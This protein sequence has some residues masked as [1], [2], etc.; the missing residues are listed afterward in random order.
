MESKSTMTL[1]ELA[2]RTPDQ[3]LLL[4]REN[5]VVMQVTAR[6]LMREGRMPGFLSLDQVESALKGSFQ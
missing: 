4:R 6:E 5:K 3:P 2:T 1:A